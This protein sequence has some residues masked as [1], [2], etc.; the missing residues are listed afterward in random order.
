MKIEDWVHECA[1]DEEDGPGNRTPRQSTTLDC[2]PFNSTHH[3]EATPRTLPTYSMV[4]GMGQA[5]EQ[6]PYMVTGG[7][8]ARQDV[9]M[10]T[11][12]VGVCFM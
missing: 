6:E 4:E 5:P 1:A 2:N 12:G 8:S 10:Q 7:Y 11:V 3:V 9:L